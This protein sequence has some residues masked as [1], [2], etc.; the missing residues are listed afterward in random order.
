MNI[1]LA[2]LCVGGVAFLLRF[3]VA[4]VNELG[5]ARLASGREGLN[6]ARY[7]PPKHRAKV[8]VMNSKARE[9]KSTAATG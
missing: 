3:L 2:I 8:V 5:G 9:S 6:F 7:S 1:A 4:L